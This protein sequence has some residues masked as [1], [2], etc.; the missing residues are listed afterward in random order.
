MM[1]LRLGIT[2]MIGLAGTLVIALPIS[3]VGIELA[4]RGSLIVGGGL[5][6][7]SVVMIVLSTI[8]TTPQDLP[9]AAAERI[10]GALVGENEDD[11]P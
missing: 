7:L 8:L 6:C 2:E 3:L 9:L 10:T 11:E 1:G 5:L 4:L